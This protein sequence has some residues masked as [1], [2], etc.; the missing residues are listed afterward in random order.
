MHKIEICGHCGGSGERTYVLDL[1][2]GKDERLDY[3]CP[4]CNG[5]GKV[6]TFM[7][8]EFSFPYDDHT[9]GN[10]LQSQI[11]KLINDSRKNK[12]F[13]EKENIIKAAKQ[14]IENR[15]DSFWMNKIIEDV[16]GEK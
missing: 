1:G 9:E 8:R 13:L 10:H 4:N 3:E 15:G 11:F 16:G 7:I 12:H 5:T 6:K 2:H 14:E